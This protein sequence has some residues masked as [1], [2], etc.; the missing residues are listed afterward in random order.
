MLYLMCV[1]INTVIIHVG[2]VDM[3]AVATRNQYVANVISHIKLTVYNDGV[4]YYYYYYYYYYYTLSSG[5]AV[6]Q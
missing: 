4:S 3:V 6:L 2:I 5:Y 1:C